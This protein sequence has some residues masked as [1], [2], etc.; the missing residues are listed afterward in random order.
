M[1][2][3]FAP[4]NPAEK[5]FTSNQN[6]YQELTRLLRLRLCPVYVYGVKAMPV[7]LH[8]P[9]LPVQRPT[10]FKVSFTAFMCHFQ[11]FFGRPCKGSGGS[12]R[13]AARNGPAGPC[14][15][16]CAGTSVGNRCRRPRTA[17]LRPGLERR[18]DRVRFQQ[19]YSLIKVGLSGSKIPNWQGAI[20]ARPC[21]APLSVWQS[22]IL[23]MVRTGCPF[24]KINEDPLTQI[25]R[26]HGLGWS[27]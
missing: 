10:K 5:P 11:H 24:T 4:Q 23:S 25:T 2:F 9:T 12:F 8:P 13:A 18:R 20:I 26:E 6:Q 3:G 17:G 21:I 15:R 14:R 1:S 22:P 27:T 7:S 19:P 16:G